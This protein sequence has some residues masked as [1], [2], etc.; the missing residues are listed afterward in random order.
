MVGLATDEAIELPKMELFELTIEHGSDF[1]LNTNRPI[2][3]WLTAHPI[4]WTRYQST[5]GYIASPM[6][7]AKP[8]PQ[9]DLIA[10]SIRCQYMLIYMKW[11]RSLSICSVRT[12]T[13]CV[14]HYAVCM[15]AHCVLQLRKSIYRSQQTRLEKVL[16]LSSVWRHWRVVVACSHSCA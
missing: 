9:S 10:I 12:A 11:L 14:P 4:E 16:F 1:E 8:G 5:H 7:V 2:K 15:L 6:A 13:Q 3:V